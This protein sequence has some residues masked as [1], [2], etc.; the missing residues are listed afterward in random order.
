MQKKTMI[1]L[2]KQMGKSTIIVIDDQLWNGEINS[3]IEISLLQ[4]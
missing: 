1:F 3:S 4:L 2:E